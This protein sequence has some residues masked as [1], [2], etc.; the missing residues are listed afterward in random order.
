MD[1]ISSLVFL[2]IYPGFSLTLIHHIG[3]LKILT[4]K[5]FPLISLKY[6]LIFSIGVNVSFLSPNHGKFRAVLFQ[7]KF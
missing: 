6:G 2:V 3:V 4:D 5:F 7:D 1:L